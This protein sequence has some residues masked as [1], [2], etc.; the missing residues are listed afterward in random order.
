MS[1]SNKKFT[2]VG[3]IDKIIEQ[4]R[5]GDLPSISVLKNMLARAIEIFSNEPTIV[6]VNAPIT[7]VGD[8]HGQFFDVLELFRIGGAPPNT[9]YLFMGDFVDR[10]FYSV[11]TLML[12]LA[13]KIRYPR[14][15]ILIRG[16]HESRIISKQYGFYL[17]CYQK[18]GD[19][20]LFWNECCE[21]FDT[22][23]LCGLIDSKIFC[24]HGG[25]SPCID[26]LSE[27]TKINRIQDP[28]MNGAFCDLLWSDPSEENDEFALSPRGAGYL[29]GSKIVHSFCHNNNLELVARAHQL[30]DAGYRYMFNNKL[31]TVWSAPNYCYRCGNVASILEIDEHLNTTIKV[32]D[33]APTEDRKTVGAQIMTEKRVPSH[34]L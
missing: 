12:L 6:S 15:M 1:S 18:F 28:P 16:N 26:S 22:M 17:E 8:V 5:G 11:E 31:I 23:P 25:L 32:F 24:V 9:N 27:I 33:S 34:F 13:Y 19:G 21:V 10:G 2:S 29:F 30:Q 14:R 20:G 7:L 4:I 3:D